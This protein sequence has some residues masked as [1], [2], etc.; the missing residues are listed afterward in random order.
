MR[1]IFTSRVI[2]RCWKNLACGTIIVQRFSSAAS[3]G[4]LTAAQ[5][6]T[7]TPEAIQSCDIWIASQ[8]RKET[9]IG[10]KTD[11]DA[12]VWMDA[13]A[14]A[15]LGERD[16]INLGGVIQQGVVEGGNDYRITDINAYASIIGD[17]TKI[18]LERL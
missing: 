6:V 10:V 4:F 3:N 11:A 13:Q 18:E 2:E 8:H 15:S 1:S 12:I 5:A 14:A 17:R 7:Y 9:R 16:I